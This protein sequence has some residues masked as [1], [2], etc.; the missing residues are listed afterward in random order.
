MLHSWL[1][2]HNTADSDD[3]S[4]DDDDDE[5]DDVEDEAKP[6]VAARPAPASAPA[7]KATVAKPQAAASVIVCADCGDPRPPTRGAKPRVW[8]CD[9]CK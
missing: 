4:S 3:E 7:I 9:R 2:V 8:H 6:A 5:A 1:A